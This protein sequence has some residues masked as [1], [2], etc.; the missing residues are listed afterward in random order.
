MKIELEYII[1]LLKHIKR[2]YQDQNNPISVKDGRKLYKAQFKTV[3]QLFIKHHKYIDITTLDKAV[4]CYL[5]GHGI[6][7][8]TFTISKPQ[9][10]GNK[11][12]KIGEFGNHINEYKNLKGILLAQKIVNL[13]NNR[14]LKVTQEYNLKLTQY[15][16][17]IINQYTGQ[18]IINEYDL[19]PIDI[20]QL[21]V[22][23][24]STSIHFTDGKNE[25]RFYHAKNTLFRSFNINIGIIEKS[26][27]NNFLVVKTCPHCN[28]ILPKEY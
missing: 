24:N 18:L 10:L 12:E 8:K 25:F 13:Y 9:D 26:D 23:K 14:L 22:T 5:N 4:D 2:N 28:H 6:A 3:E 1:D 16:C 21:K 19:Y 27:I 7:I 11:S 15:F 20:N 17:S